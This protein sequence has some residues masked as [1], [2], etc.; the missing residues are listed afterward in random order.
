MSDFIGRDEVIVS[1][2][3]LLDEGP[4]LV[5]VG[6][7]RVGK[8]RLLKAM[9]A[10]HD[11]PLIR[12][13]LEGSVSTEQAIAHIQHAVASRSAAAG[14]DQ[15]VG[16][17]RGY[18]QVV[19]DPAGVSPW[20]RLADD[21][22]ELRRSFGSAST[23]TIALDEVPWWLEALERRT[24]GAAREALGVLRSLRDGGRWPKLRWIL[25]G[26]VG[27]AGRAIAWNATGEINDLPK[28]VLPPL[29]EVDGAHLFRL[30]AQEA[31][32][33]PVGDTPALA[34][35]LAGGRP[36][37]IGLLASKSARRGY[38]VQVAD[39]DAA[40]ERLLDRQT[41]DLFDEEGNSHFQRMYAPNERKTV[42][43]I[44]DVLSEVPQPVAEPGVVMA[45]LKAGAADPREVRDVLC[46]LIDDFYLCERP[47][48]TL[49]YAL[50]LF[51]RWWSRWGTL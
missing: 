22:E 41:R 43:A 29:A 31:G 46:R 1:L 17:I 36:H 33:S 11:R 49:A 10:A 40:V 9:E 39:L 5:L 13:T 4:G 51:G 50:P 37:W 6:A 28:V 48:N 3:K 38:P 15:L 24:P 47:D 14:L 20:Y 23:L 44:F 19:V 21:L 32:G 30:R 35:R 26:S 18:G 34:C 42:R 25:T 27:L 12:V 8:S 2:S 45:A 7:R 16:R